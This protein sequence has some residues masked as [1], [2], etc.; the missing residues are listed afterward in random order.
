MV[1]IQHSQIQKHLQMT[2]EANKAL[3]KQLNELKESAVQQIGV[4]AH[5][6][7]IYSKP[8][9]NLIPLS[10]I[11]YLKVNYADI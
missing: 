9:L 7:K 5:N 1:N 10:G 6:P 4:F 3:E 2:E 8:N 11:L